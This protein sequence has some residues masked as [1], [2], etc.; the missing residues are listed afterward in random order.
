MKLCLNLL[1]WFSRSSDYGG[2]SEVSIPLLEIFFNAFRN[3]VN[4]EVNYEV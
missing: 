4:D 2:A 1:Q 3:A